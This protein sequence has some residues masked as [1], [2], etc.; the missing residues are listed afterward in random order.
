MTTLS[1]RGV[2]SCFSAC[3]PTFNPHLLLQVGA[4]IIS[5]PHCM[6]GS[7]EKQSN[8]SKATQPSLAGLGLELGSL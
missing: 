6:L 4:V 5:T 1:G 3:V 7:S 8:L 2:R